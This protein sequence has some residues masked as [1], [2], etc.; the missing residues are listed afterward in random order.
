MEDYLM[1]HGVLGQKWGVRR[2]QNYDGS[3]TQAGMKR[4]S[5]SLQSY[6][7]AKERYATAKSNKLSKAEITNARMR[8]KEA[9]A[10]LKKDYKHL[11]QDKLGDQGKEL[12][13]RGHTITG[14]SRVTELL[15]SIGTI[16]VSAAIKGQQAGYFDKRVATIIAS[17]GSVSLASAG[18]MTLK[19]E[20]DARRLRAYYGHTSNY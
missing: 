16:A 19:S 2:Y 12:Y 18:V 5:A 20:H 15:G 8:K 7:N 1:H 14:E 9:K 3:Y 17:A 10:K 6:N 4:Y 11:K 13:S